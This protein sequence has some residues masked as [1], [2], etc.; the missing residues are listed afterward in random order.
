MEFP[1][2]V[3]GILQFL[4]LYTWRGTIQIIGALDIEVIR[5]TIYVNDNW[6]AAMQSEG[7]G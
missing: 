6:L 1:E 4:S 5:N 2:V 3:T 7:A